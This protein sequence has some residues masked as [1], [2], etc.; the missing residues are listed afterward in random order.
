MHLLVRNSKIRVRMSLDR[1]TKPRVILA[2]RSVPQPRGRLRPR[3]KSLGSID[4][5]IAEP[6]C[7][8]AF[9]RSAFFHHVCR[10][11]CRK[12]RVSFT[13]F[14]AVPRSK[15]ASPCSHKEWGAGDQFA[16]CPLPRDLLAKRER[17]L[18]VWRGLLVSRSGQSK[19][20]SGR[21][22]RSKRRVNRER[23]LGGERVDRSDQWRGWR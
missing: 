6:L 17:P 2:V 9:N 11:D 8:V 3:T 10:G 15:R 21:S 19:T 5:R 1:A 13:G 4:N 22:D 20:R 18:C 23:D 7:T 14:H 16:R 12:Q